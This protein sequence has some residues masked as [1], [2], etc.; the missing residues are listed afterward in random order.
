MA[1]T[2]EGRVKAKV[3]QQLKALDA[4][5]FFP[6]TGGFGAS[7]VPDVVG[8][9][10]G[11]FFAIECKAGNNKPTLLQDRH[12]K[13]IS[14]AGGYSWV[15]NEKNVHLVTEALRLYGKTKEN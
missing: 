13:R 9:Y 7:G 5:Y 11:C 6:A 1:S 15:V 2:P 4:Y 14:Q 8:C 12:I 10:R 3:V